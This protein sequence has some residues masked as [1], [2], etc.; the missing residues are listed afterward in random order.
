MQRKITSLLVILLF[1]GFS[2]S[3][4]QTNRWVHKKVQAKVVN[5]KVVNINHP[6]NLQKGLRT[7]KLISAQKILAGDLIFTMNPTNVY[8]GYDL[9]SNGTPQELWANPQT[10]EL[11]A[12][13]IYSPETGNNWPDRTVQYLYS[14]D[15]GTTW[16]TPG[17]VPPSGNRSGYPAVSGFMSDGAALIAC[18]TFDNA[19][20]ST[21]TLVFRDDGSGLG[22]FS[23]EYDPGYPQGV[24]GSNA[25][26]WPRLAV[27]NDNSFVIESS[28][29][30]GGKDSMFVDIYNGSAFNGWQSFP[31]DQAETYRVAV[32]EDS[33]I[34]G[35]AY[36]GN[37]STANSNFGCVFYQQ[38]TDMGTTW[39][40]M[41]TLWNYSD[42]ANNPD[43]LAAIRGL[44][45][46]FLGDQPCVTFNLIK[47][48]TA[49]TF[50]PSFP[51]KIAFWSPMANNGN[52]MMVA[53]SNNVP[54]Y[55]DYEGSV[56][57]FAPICR[58]A[59]GRSAKGD[60]LFLAFSATTPYFMGDTSATGV[61]NTYYTG[62]IMTSLDSGNTWTAP[63]K[64]TPDSMDWGGT[65]KLMDWRYI[66]VTQMSP[67]TDSICTI[68]IVVQGDTIPGS[69]VN[70][71]AGF[72][73]SYA[74]LYN[75]N[76][77]ITIPRL[78]VNSV[79]NNPN[80]PYT[81]ALHQNYPNPFNPT[82]KINYSVASRS[83]VSLKIYDIL[84]REV[85][86]LVNTE[87]NPGNYTINFD[88]SKLASGIYL[89]KLTAGNYI[90]TKKMVLLK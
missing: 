79:N 15:G 14:P 51:S 31:G 49:G 12:A 34:V 28:Q 48:Y 27:I 11:H 42:F 67:V 70:I 76:A 82:T 55:Y 75:F 64:F 7:D 62:M 35:V 2:F 85:T 21:R 54:Y 6:V 10:G 66:S 29:N 30:T 87:K 19:D 81:F 86:T 8:T 22:T 38:T 16:L 13:L 26:I 1:A 3:Q 23:T 89:Y 71:P 40:N 69:E 72:D 9:Q 56:D 60:A 37:G 73:T 65:Y 43:T 36:I 45:M 46:V 33:T 24:T 78:V 63:V 77:Q 5:E 25:A 41:D 90:S 4:A 50:F 59:I 44:D 74:S 58:P 32:S 53:D 68:Q 47:G 83:I 18:H 39:S 88:A 80:S 20:P 52:L 84:G 57:V 17:V 61:A